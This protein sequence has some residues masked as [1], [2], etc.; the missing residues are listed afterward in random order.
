VP[1]ILRF[2]LLLCLLDLSAATGYANIFRNAAERHTLEG[3]MRR[4]SKERQ[5]CDPK[6]A[7]EPILCCWLSLVWTRGSFF[8]SVSPPS[9]RRLWKKC[10]KHKLA[11]LIRQNTPMNQSLVGGPRRLVARHVVD[12]GGPTCRRISYYFFGYLHSEALASAGG[13]FVRW[14]AATFIKNER[15]SA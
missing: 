14:A 6:T 5:L 11:A 8:S 7:A 12:R 2:L 1:W 15:S 13:L 10:N 4:I 9:R 3:F